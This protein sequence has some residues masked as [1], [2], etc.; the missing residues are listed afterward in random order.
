MI[1]PRSH[2]L[3]RPSGAALLRQRLLDGFAATGTDPWLATEIARALGVSVLSTR[4]AL[5]ALAAEGR[6]EVVARK[7]YTVRRP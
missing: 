4:Q 1:A 7:P 2:K 5:E 3:R 6:I